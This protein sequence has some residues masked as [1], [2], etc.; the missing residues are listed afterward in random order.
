[1]NQFIN[2]H[3]KNYKNTSF[4]EYYRALI[5]MWANYFFILLISI[6]LLRALFSNFSDSLLLNLGLPASVLSLFI[7]DIFLLHY[8]TKSQTPGNFLVVALL[9][10]SI[11]IAYYSAPILKMY[12]YTGMYFYFIVTFSLSFIFVDRRFLFINAII[13]LIGY[14][15]VYYRLITYIEGEQ[16]IKLAKSGRVNFHIAIIGL[17]S[18]I[19]SLSSLTEKAMLRIENARK[20]QKNHSQQLKTMLKNV[21][22]TVSSILKMSASLS[23]YSQKVSSTSAEQ[24]AS[25]EEISATFEQLSNSLNEINYSTSETDNFAKEALVN[26]NDNIVHFE[27]TTKTINKTKEHSQQIEEIAA[28]TEILAI[29]ASIEISRVSDQKAG[30]SNVASEIRNLAELTMKTASDVNYLAQQSHELSLNSYQNIQE[31]KELMAELEQRIIFIAH[32]VYE[33]KMT[34]EQLNHGVLEISNASQ[35]NTSVA[36]NLIQMVEALNQSSNQLKALLKN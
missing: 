6:V 33:Q 3:L 15:L 1:M 35:E 19:L 5:L 8:S 36:E 17:S 24:A 14:N 20:R 27:T 29:N 21:E 7:I 22:T 26:L 11:V 13:I 23:V 34:L 32:G 4:A 9:L 28:K 18:I 25:I 16:M 31:I 30:F 2:W 10:V 12:Y